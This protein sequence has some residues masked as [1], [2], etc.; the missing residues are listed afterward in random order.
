MRAPP[1]PRR[2]AGVVALLLA[3]ASAASVAPA[4]AHEPITTAA[5]N[6]LVEQ[7]AKLNAVAGDTRARERAEAACD[8][9]AKM[10]FI[11]QVL[12]RDLAQH[13]KLGMNSQVLAEQLKARGVAVSF[14]PEM[15]RYRAYLSPLEICVALAPDSAKRNAALFRLVRGR[16]YDSFLY[17][18][19]KPIGL[20]WQRLKAGIAAA[21]RF[22]S[23]RPKPTERE[24]AAFILAVDYIRAARM[25]PDSTVA[26]AYA[27]RAR[28]ALTEFVAAFPDSMRVGAA[29]V[30]LGAIS[31]DK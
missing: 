16:F 3:A 31:A 25:A 6:A 5:A 7:I 28:A 23:S 9:G 26:R 4:S 17:D 12:N 19:L 29:K 22:L 13:G 30:L 1:R 21:E 8:L 11:V 2:A 20:N 27:G 18:P 10:E 24:E 14:Q 15:R